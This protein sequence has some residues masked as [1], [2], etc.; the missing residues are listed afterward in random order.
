MSSIITSFLHTQK[1]K[2]LTLTR[3]IDDIFIIWT[4]TAET[5]ASFLQDLNTFHPNLHFTHE[6]STTSV[7]FLD[8]T[9]FKGQNFPY[10]NTL[11]LK[12]FQK[13]LNLYQY[14]HYTSSHQNQ[15]YKSIIRGEC[16]R[17]IRTNT[18][19]ESYCAT[20]HMFKQRL[21]KR[22]YPGTLIDKVIQ[23]VRYSDRPK[24][25]Q[26]HQKHQP[27]CLPP[28]V[29]CIPPPRY[30]LLKQIILQNYAQLK[31]ITL[32]CPTPRHIT[33]PTS[34]SKTTPHGQPTHMYIF[35]GGGMPPDPPRWRTHPVNK[36]D[37]C[38]MHG[39]G[40]GQVMC[41]GKPVSVCDGS[42]SDCWLMECGYITCVGQCVH[43]GCN[44]HL[45][46]PPSVAQHKHHESQHQTL[47][48]LWGAQ[49]RRNQKK[50]LHGK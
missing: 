21:L 13:P 30:K 16:I 44:G 49:T 24:Y 15:V 20:L 17:Y 2:P 47:R 8:L 28:L 23:T 46:N 34:S 22:G 35:P 1:I 4:D 11:D 14:L 9:I 43:G 5:L 40:P 39:Y 45:Y 7:N 18:T 32:H 33:E 38:V 29:K 37:H 25:L 12:T 3:Y 41:C 6:H 10:T 26:P 50:Q 36:L 19:K 48:S 42:D 27:T 31:F